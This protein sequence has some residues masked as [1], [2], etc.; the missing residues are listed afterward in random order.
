MQVYKQALQ[1]NQ[2]IPEAKATTLVDNETTPVS[3]E[4]IPVDN[5]TTPVDKVAETSGIVSTYEI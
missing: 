4:T 3:K 1:L 2:N 5:E